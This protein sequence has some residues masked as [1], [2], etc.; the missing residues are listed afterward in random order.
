MLAVRMSELREGDIQRIRERGMVPHT[1]A[2]RTE[3]GIRA[4]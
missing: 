1:W 4:A 3:Q 2:V